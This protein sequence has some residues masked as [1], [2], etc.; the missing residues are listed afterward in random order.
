MSDLDVVPAE[1]SKYHRNVSVYS[2]ATVLGLVIFIAFLV[3]APHLPL[4]MDDRNSVIG[5]LALICIGCIFTALYFFGRDNGVP[6][7]ILL[8]IFVSIVI[9]FYGAWK[10]QF[11]I[12][13]YFA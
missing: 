5:I 7:K 12:A 11:P 2:I 1:T 6:V 3:V 8:A 10:I 9:L 4:S 13:H